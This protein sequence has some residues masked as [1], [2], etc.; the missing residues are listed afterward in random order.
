MTLPQPDQIGLY[1]QEMDMDSGWRPSDLAHHGITQSYGTDPTHLASGV[2]H[3]SLAQPSPDNTGID[4]TSLIV[5]TQ[6]ESLDPNHGYEQI[7][8]SFS[9]IPDAESTRTPYLNLTSLTAQHYAQPRNDNLDRNHQYDGIE[10]DMAVDAVSDDY[11]AKLKAISILQ[12]ASTDMLTATVNSQSAARDRQLSITVKTIRACLDDN[13]G[14]GSEIEMISGYEPVKEGLLP[15]D[16]FLP[17]AAR[18][19]V[20]TTSTDISG[21]SSLTRFVDM[22]TISWTRE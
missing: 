15:E 19:A 8:S 2:V 7:E 3:S 14:A 21:S 5:T 13:F 6:T 11:H 12:R 20:C 4:H 1:I 22:L 10:E 9:N 17:E 16:G 18:G